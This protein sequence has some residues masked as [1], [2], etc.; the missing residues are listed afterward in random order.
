MFSMG[1]IVVFEL[2]LLETITLLRNA[3]PLHAL[4]LAK[5]LIKPNIIERLGLRYIDRVVGQN[6]QDIA[7]LVKP[8]IAG[9]ASSDFGQYLHQTINESLFVMSETGEQIIA[10]W[11][12]VPE[13]IT[14]DPQALEPIAEPSWIFDLDMSLSKTR[15]FNIKELVREAEKFAQRTYTFFRWAVKDEFLLRYG[16]KI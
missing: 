6:Y 3:L 12:V 7:L 11:G 1:G 13:N 4:I 5:V 9:I 2:S 14:F 10:R 8:E 16:G 15:E